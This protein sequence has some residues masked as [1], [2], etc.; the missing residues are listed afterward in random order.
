MQ[1]AAVHWY[2]VYYAWLLY[3]Q[4]LYATQILR[5]GQHE[6]RNQR[7]EARRQRSQQRRDHSDGWAAHPSISQV[8][9]VDDGV[10]NCS[11]ESFTEDR[12]PAPAGLHDADGDHHHHL[13]HRQHD[14][15]R[16]K[17]PRSYHR[18]RFPLNDSADGVAAAAD[19]DGDDANDAGSAVARQLRAQVQHLEEKVAALSALVT[20][21]AGEA[22]LRGHGKAAPRRVAERNRGYVAAGDNSRARSGEDSRDSFI[23]STHA[24]AAQQ[25]PISPST[26]GTWQDLAERQ[27]SRSGANTGRRPRASPQRPQW[28]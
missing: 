24:A 26:A 7:R 10:R 12:R 19:D 6:R 3:Y 25:R 16:L 23:V 22:S 20:D 2:E 27:R 28:R 17:L 13:Y 11:S 18:R 1:D 14:M 9:E 15:K 4:Q 8:M 21:G 5:S